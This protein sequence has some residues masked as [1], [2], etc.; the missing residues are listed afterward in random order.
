M[1]NINVINAIWDLLAELQS[2]SPASKTPAA[3]GPVAGFEQAIDHMVA[4]QNRICKEIAQASIEKAKIQAEK[5]AEFQRQLAFL[6]SQLQA[7]RTE[8]SVLEG[9]KNVSQALQGTNQLL[10]F[11]TAG[12]GL[13]GRQATSGLAILGR[14]RIAACDAGLIKS[15]KFLVYSLR[16]NNQKNRQE[17]DSSFWGSVP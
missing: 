4:E 13:L 7:A 3:D 14:G 9:S 2:P 11:Q 15:Q 12:S 16:L 6:T 1:E 17:E 8:L 5:L 10:D